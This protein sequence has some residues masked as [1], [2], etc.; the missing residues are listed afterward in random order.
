MQFLRIIPVVLLF[1]LSCLFAGPAV[2]APHT[3]SL[4]YRII[5]RHCTQMPDHNSSYRV[6][7]LWTVVGTVEKVENFNS[8]IHCEGESDS[9]LSYNS[10]FASSLAFAE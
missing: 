4:S 5:A 7:L 2:P 3:V 1:I 10:N 8:N 9:E 6:S